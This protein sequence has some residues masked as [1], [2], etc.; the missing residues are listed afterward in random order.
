MSIDDLY[1][2]TPITGLVS[3]I[4]P[5]YNR[6]KY[7]LKAIESVRQQTY[8][9]L[10][11]IVVDD[12]S[13][14]VEYSDLVEEFSSDP[15]V[16]ILRLL[17]NMRTVHQTTA[18]QGMTRWEG[19]K[20]AKGEW[21]AFLDDDDYWYPTKLEQQLNALNRVNDKGLF[22]MCCSNMDVAKG[23]YD[24]SKQTRIYFKNGQVDP[25][26]T[27]ELITSINHVNN[28]TVILHRDIIDEVG[29]F[30]T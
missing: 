6:Y 9:L 8:K 12:C 27:S 21:I 22:K 14:Q 30:K 17:V 10:E 20:I 29:P 28:S 16:T 25:I 11:I 18:A 2:T 13:T 23:I 7:V 1:P 26:L 15:R 19:I 4:I 3:V 5:T 24:P